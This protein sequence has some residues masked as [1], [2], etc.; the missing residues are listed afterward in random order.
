MLDPFLVEQRFELLMQS[1]PLISATRTRL[2]RI[3][4]FLEVLLETDSRLYIS[5]YCPELL[6]KMWEDFNGVAADE[7]SIAIIERVM[8]IVSALKEKYDGLSAGT[9]LDEVHRYLLTES[10]RYNGHNTAKQRNGL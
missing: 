2:L 3:A 10:D 6:A 1:L 5:V 4:E 8:P 9:T 7:L